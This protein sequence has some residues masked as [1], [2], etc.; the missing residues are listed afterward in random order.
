MS[1]TRGVG[2]R[3]EM[4]RI[5]GMRSGN[6]TRRGRTEWQYLTIRASCCPCCNSRRTA[7]YIPRE[8]IDKLSVHFG[9]TDA[10]RLE[11]LPSGRQP[12]FDNRV[13]WARTYMTKAGLLVSPKRG[14]IQITARGRQ[15][16]A[17]NPPFI[18][19]AYL[20]RFPEF[21]AFR[22][23]RH[24]ADAED[25]S[26]PVRAVAGETPE[27]QLDSAYLELRENLAEELLKQIVKCAPEYFERVVVDLL[28]AMGY[29]GSVREAGRAI[30]RAGD[31]GID[32]IIKE[33]QLGLDIIY[34]QAKRWEG[35]V[36]RPEIQRFAGALLGQS[37]RKGIFVT[38][39]SF[40]PEARDYV[41]RL[42][43][44]IILIDGSQFAE[45]MID[46]NVGV[47]T[48]ARCEIKRIDSDYFAEE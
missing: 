27:E 28:V 16:L 13:G 7:P 22:Q 34:I 47:T 25:V 4:L 31:G 37:A 12:T 30:G 14:Q 2:G 48:A 20:E 33:D 6:S 42:D 8:A 18:N 15:V 32:G 26:Q 3:R 35:K 10:E 36:G 29:G 17:E 21:I 5:R 11:L 39:S 41:S 24:G 46:H 44:K 19:V 1:P 43:S 23:L 45:L 38:T 9:V 40:T